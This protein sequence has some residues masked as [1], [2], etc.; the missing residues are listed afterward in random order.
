MK[1]AHILS[2]KSPF[3]ATIK[4]GAS[5]KHLVDELKKYGIGAL[6]V[7][8]DGRRIDGIVSERD[9]VRKLSEFV[10]EVSLLK[11]ED[12][13]TRDVFTCSADDDVEKLMEVMTEH[14]FRHVPVVEDDGS[15][16][17]VVSI[18]DLVKYRIEELHDERAALINYIT[19]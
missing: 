16:F 8:E 7:S 9:I 12:I 13:M 14:K 3:V 18:G 1:I 6:I 2:N 4:A 17:G 10:G 5:V 19:N 15:L 11:V